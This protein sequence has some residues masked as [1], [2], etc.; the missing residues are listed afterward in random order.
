MPFEINSTYPVT[1]PVRQV[2]KAEYLFVVSKPKC[3]D[4]EHELRRAELTTKR[5][6]SI[7]PELSYIAVHVRD[8]V[9][10]KTAAVLSLEAENRKYGFTMEYK[11]CSKDEFYPFSQRQKH[12]IIEHLA[13]SE[14]D[15]PKYFSGYG[16]YKENK[17]LVDYFPLHDPSKEDIWKLWGK[18]QFLKVFITWFVF[19]KTDQ[20][21]PIFLLGSYFGEKVGLYFAWTT[22]Y[23][24][25]L[26]YLSIPS[27]VLSVFQLST[28]TFDHPL[29]L[30]YSLIVSLWI[31][32]MN[33]MWRRRE[34]S[35][36]R[37]W[38][39]HD[40]RAKSTERRDY[41]HEFDVDERTGEIVKVSFVR[42]SILKVFFS[43]PMILFGFGLVAAAFIGFRVW[44]GLN[45]S[46]KNTILVGAINGASIFVLGAVYTFVARKLTDLENYRYEDQWENSF[47]IKI[48][49][50]QF[51]N[52]YISLFAIAFY[53]GSFD[54]IAY[55]LGAIFLV[56]QF[57]T[58]VTKIVLPYILNVIKLRIMHKKINALENDKTV[59][60]SRD[61]EME[62][63]RNESME[64]IINY[65]E[66]II[67]LGYISMFSSALP[68]CVVFALLRNMLLI[69][70]WLR[71]MVGE[72]FSSLNVCRRPVAAGVKG[73]GTWSGILEVPPSHP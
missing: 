49:G 54:S 3:K 46:F 50:F 35:L 64:T 42:S 31:T 51:V 5:Y 41:K 68:V 21:L 12:Q 8:S 72:I 26:A 34:N 1:T 63:N 28:M 2:A 27:I 9:Y 33:Q 4:F 61:L 16:S 39:M 55:S 19:A 57:L 18:G 20:L 32:I 58:Y 25:F 29:I 10:Q 11:A 43:L 14:I 45:S 40:F 70:G 24:G 71:V 60:V 47:I 48:F 13:A 37:L 30:L 56:K 59:K 69:K 15:L 38:N 22:F 67:Q 66:M 7:D 23:T 53:D 6:D 17:I 52:C 73:I 44:D 62:Y 36:I 65:C